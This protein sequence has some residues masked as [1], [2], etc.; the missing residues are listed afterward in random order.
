MGQIRSRQPLSDA[1]FQSFIYQTLCGLKVSPTHT[2]RTVYTSAILT[3]TVYPLGQRAAPRFETGES[4][5][6][7]RLRVEDLRL[8]FG[9]RIPAW[10]GPDRA[11]SSRFHDRVWVSNPVKAVT[12]KR[13][14]ELNLSRR[15]YTMVPSARDY[16]QFRKLYRIKYAPSSMLT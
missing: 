16:A 12:I 14:C 8:W 1:H 6:E 13:S 15:R 4:A 11:G 7:C 2:I 5:R 3:G 10:C 9:K